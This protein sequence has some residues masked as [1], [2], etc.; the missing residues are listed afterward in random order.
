MGKVGSNSHPIHPATVHF[1]IAFLCLSY[2]LDIVYGL[3]TLPA[4]A[5]FVRNTYNIAP[6]L[7]EISRFSHYLNILG[8]ITAVPAVVTGGIELLAMIKKQDLANKLQKSQNKSS[9]VQRMHPKLKI[10]FVHAALNDVAVFGSGYNWWT[11]SSAAG[12]APSD[13]NVLL[14]LAM[15]LFISASGYLGGMMV[16]EYGV[17]V[18]RQ[19]EG[20]RLKES[21]KAE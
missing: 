9:T 2:F 4:T 15:L 14:S 20:K 13:L 3:A 1:P 21:G 10:G 18:M 19:G 5:G 8:L 6:F 7:G 11:R 17:G 12:Y 16:Y